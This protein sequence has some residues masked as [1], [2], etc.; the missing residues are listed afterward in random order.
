MKYIFA[1]IGMVTILSVSAACAQA[2]NVDRPAH[3]E[4]AWKGGKEL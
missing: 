4:L 3:P 1:K 2:Q